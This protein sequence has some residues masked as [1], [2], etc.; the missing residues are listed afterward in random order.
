MTVKQLILVGAEGL[1]QNSNE[2]RL[3]SFGWKELDRLPNLA[4]ADAILLNLLSLSR[5][6]L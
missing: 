3:R 5:W 4:D 6:S 2:I 1:N